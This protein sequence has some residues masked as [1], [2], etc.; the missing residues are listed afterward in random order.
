MLINNK[1][2]VNKIYFN[3]IKYCG[4]LKNDFKFCKKLNDKLKTQINI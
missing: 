3:E 1:M 4:K 2:L